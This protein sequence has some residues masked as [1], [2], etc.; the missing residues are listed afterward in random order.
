MSK[1]AS[2]QFDCVQSTR[3]AR[4]KVSESIADMP[5][6]DLVAWVR[7]HRYADPLLERLAAKAAQQA[8]ATQGTSTGW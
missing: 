5:Y 1:T 2:K 4:D 3:E 6:D 8:D 7:S